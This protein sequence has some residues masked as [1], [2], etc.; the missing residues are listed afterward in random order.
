MIVWSLSVAFSEEPMSTAGIDMDDLSVR[1]KMIM[2]K[3][4]SPGCQS[5]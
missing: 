3:V 1:Q 2:A 4:G 5:A